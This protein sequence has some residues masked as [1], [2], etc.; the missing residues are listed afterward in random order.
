MKRL[1]HLVIF[2][3]LIAVSCWGAFELGRKSQ[4]SKEN[5][6]ASKERRVPA[7]R[8][9]FR[10]ARS[11]Q[12]RTRLLRDEL[13]QCVTA[14]EFRAAID[15]LQFR[16]D[17]SE[18][19]R[20][21]SILFQRWLE[22]SPLDALAGVRRV[23]NLRHDILRTSRVFETWAID[24]PNEARLLLKDVLDGRQQDLASQPPFLD[25]VDPPE[26]LLSLVAGL[27]KVDPAS[28]AVLLGE[29]SGSPVRFH[30]L[31]VLLQN[32][33][34]RDAKAVFRWAEGLD[35]VALREQVISKAAAKAGQLD[36]PQQGIAW[37]QAL[38]S[39]TEQRLA[40]GALTRQWAARHSRE[41]FRWVEQ[42]ADELKFHLIPPVISSLTKVDPGGA[43]D[44]LNQ[45]EAA[46][47]MDPAVASYAE[48]LKSVN[49]TAAM[50]SA[51]AITEDSLREKVM[52][53]IAKEW[54]TANPVKFGAYLDQREGL[55]STVYELKR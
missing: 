38:G 27:A 46:P 19:N 53:T 8:D 42:Q 36:D 48:A 50:D 10:E 44:W 22:V 24:N 26:Y 43:A 31:D 15:R 33:F 13:D 5:E 52:L 37:A 30:A 49:P 11:D 41:A 16:A 47:K 28:T 9:S 51:A 20:L 25:G 6:S 18:E 23:E 39:P 7:N 12:D 54:K 1:R 3:V 34:P 29:M 45:F 40:L 21:L 55:P 32:W 17:K 2:V 35:Q 4:S 14:D